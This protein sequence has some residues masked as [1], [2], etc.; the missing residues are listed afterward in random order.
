MMTNLKTGVAR[1][2]RRVDYCTKAAAVSPGGDCPRW[3]E[4]LAEITD[5]DAEL[6]SYMQRMAGYCTTGITTEH[7]MFFCHGTGANGKSVF[8]NT[9]AGIWGDY[10]VT[11]PMETFTVSRSDRHPTDL[12]MLRGARLVVAQETEKG[13]CWAES[14]IKA[15]TGGDRISARF[16]RQDF[17]EFTPQFKLLIAGNH[18]PGLRGVDEAIRRR[19]HLIPFNVTIPPEK[20][21]PRLFEELKTEWKGI[22]RWAIDGSIE[23]QRIGLVPPRAVVDA[24]ERYLASEDSMANWIE[25]RCEEDPGFSATRAGL[26]NDW[27]EWAENGGEHPGAAKEFFDTLEQRGFRQF[28]DRGNRKFRGLRLMPEPE[29][30]IGTRKKD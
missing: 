1:E 17:F 13:R 26:F 29:V 14:K 7:V 25:D 18:K 6:Q 8:I 23:W 19:L 11:A 27:K 20:R 5:G 2:S 30:R 12:A 28:K 16:M 15:L 24:T 21:N 10:A 9:L 22:L 4:F 3:R